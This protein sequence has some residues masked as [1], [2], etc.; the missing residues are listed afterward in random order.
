MALA[1]V[2]LRRRPLPALA[3]SRRSFI[4]PA[5][6]KQKSFIDREALSLLHQDF[7]GGRDDDNDHDDEEST[8]ISQK[9]SSSAMM[10]MIIM[11]TLPRS[12]WSDKCRTISITCS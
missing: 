3:S 9:C 7:G 2:P 6:Q 11:Q 1:V 12:C 8:P 10:M 5:K 4:V